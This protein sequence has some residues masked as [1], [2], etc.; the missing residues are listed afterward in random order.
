MRNALAPRPT[1][2]AV[3]SLAA[4]APPGASLAR[5]R[6]AQPMRD[7]PEQR[8]AASIREEATGDRASCDLQGRCGQSPYREAQATTLCA[9]GGGH[10]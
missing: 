10:E 6:S 9:P 4:S 5:G 7:G 3:R 1:L 8:P 2:P